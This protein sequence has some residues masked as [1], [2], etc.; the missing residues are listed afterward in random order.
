PVLVPP[1]ASDGHGLIVIG[2]ASIELEQNIDDFTFRGSVVGLDASTGEEQWRLPGSAGGGG[3]GPLFRARGRDL[4]GVGDK[5][6]PFEVFE[7]GTGETV[8]GRELTRGSRLGG[9]MTT[10]A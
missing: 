9:V 8:W 1:P 6:G 5:A 10:A 2:V 4:V 3:A 7:R